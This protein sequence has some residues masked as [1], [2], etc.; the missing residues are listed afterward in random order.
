MWANGIVLSDEQK[1]EIKKR[2]YNYYIA[3]KGK[4]IKEIHVEPVFVMALKKLME[5]LINE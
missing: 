4:D 2:V 5:M 3:E 1:R